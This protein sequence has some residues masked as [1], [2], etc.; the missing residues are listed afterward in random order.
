MS[1][2][3]LSPVATF[4]QGQQAQDPAQQAVPPPPQ[5]PMQASPLLNAIDVNHDGRIDGAELANAPA[6]LKTLDKNGD[7]KLTRDEGGLPAGYGRVAGPG[8][9]GGR[10]GGRGEAGRGEAARGAEPAAGDRRFEVPIPGPTADELL[11]LLMSFDKNKD[12]KLSKAEIPERQLGLLER[13][14]T[15]KNGVLDAAE[16]KKVTAEQAAAPPAPP[17]APRGGWGNI[18]LASIALD[19]DRNAEI[20]AEEIANAVAALTT[21]DKNADGV[22]TEDE[23]RPAPAGRGRGMQ[24]VSLEPQAVS[25]S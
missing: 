5:P 15:D 3:L 9:A 10:E 22:I 17:R 24:A 6:R 7:G 19:T 18:D 23:A 13:G 1:A 21:L 16:L 2:A 14:D 11:E 4:T 20:S 8:R 25:R 12:G